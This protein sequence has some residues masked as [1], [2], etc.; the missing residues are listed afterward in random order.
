M[1]VK[2]PAIAHVPAPRRDPIGNLIAS[3]RPLAP[4]QRALSEFGYGP[5]ETNGSFG[6]ETRAAIERFERDHKMPVTGQLSDRLIRE[7]SVMTGRAL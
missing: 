6:P 2:A 5:V 4:I 3:S 7:L 1:P